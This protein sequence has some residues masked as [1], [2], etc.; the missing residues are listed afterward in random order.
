[1]CGYVC[2][3]VCVF[4][5]VEAEKSNWSTQSF[6]HKKILF[7]IL[8][9]SLTTLSFSYLQGIHFSS[10][11][12]CSCMYVCVCVCVVIVAN[13]SLHLPTGGEICS[14]SLILTH[15]WHFAGHFVDFRL[16]RFWFSLFS[17]YSFCVFSYFW[18]FGIYFMHIVC[19]CVCVCEEA[20]D[21]AH[22]SF[23]RWVLLLFTLFE[24]KRF[25]S[26]LDALVSVQQPQQTL[27]VSSWSIVLFLAVLEH[28]C[29][30]REKKTLN[31]AQ[32]RIS[33]GNGY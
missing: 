3:C 5:F 19:V 8:Y 13:L 9:F 22:F 1:M 26:H 18:F 12:T 15:F 4:T 30:T 14:L 21:A 6:P 25:S 20:A 27:Q 33:N 32:K 11:H 24:E 31:P 10:L 23:L 17:L 16:L 29:S 28:T 2:V 7:F